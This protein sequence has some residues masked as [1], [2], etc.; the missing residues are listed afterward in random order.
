MDLVRLIY[1]SRFSARTGAR[2]IEDILSV[3]RSRNPKHDVT[4]VLCYAPGVFLQCLE[5]PRAAV[6]TL[7][8]AIAADKRHQDATVLEYADISERTFGKW[9]MAYVRAEDLGDLSGLIPGAGKKFD[10]F[11]MTAGE[12]LDF[13]TAIA[14]KRQDLLDRVV[15]DTRS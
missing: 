4:G 3:S 8:R 6:N 14:T 1:A 15:E 13:V 12:V 5:G 7:Y 9:S 10:P 2:E 11:A